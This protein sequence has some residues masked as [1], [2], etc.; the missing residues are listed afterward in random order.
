MQPLELRV[1]A[2]REVRRLLPYP[3]CVEAVAPR[4]K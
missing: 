4:L 1:I 3:D 2:G